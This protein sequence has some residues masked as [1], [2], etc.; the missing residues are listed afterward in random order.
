MVL[1]YLWPASLTICCGTVLLRCTEKNPPSRRRWVEIE[2]H[3]VCCH[4]CSGR[5]AQFYSPMAGRWFICAGSGYVVCAR[6]EDR[7][8]G[9]VTT[10]LQKFL[11]IVL[12]SNFEKIMAMQTVEYDLRYPIG[13]VDDQAF[14]LQRALL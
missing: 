5:W 2:R 9:R 3:S 4:L 6:Q 14:L 7:E 10:I 13:K 12:Y 1:Y 8:A 11:R